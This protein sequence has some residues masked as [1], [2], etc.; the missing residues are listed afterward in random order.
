MISLAPM[1]TI[2]VPW[3]AVIELE[4]PNREFDGHVNDGSRSAATS[5]NCDASCA[6]FLLFLAACRLIIS[7][8]YQLVLLSRVELG[9]L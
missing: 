7:S 8:F 9:H 6:A 2:I 3:A 1:D 4:T 5:E